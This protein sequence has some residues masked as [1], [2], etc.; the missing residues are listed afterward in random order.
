V[1]QTPQ[2]FRAEFVGFVT[3]KTRMT[4]VEVFKRFPRA[5]TLVDRT[6]G[7]AR[8]RLMRGV[9][10]ALHRVASRS[11]RRR[12]PLARRPLRVVHVSPA[13]F[14]E[15]SVIGGGE[16]YAT[17]L[18]TAMAEVAPTT[19]VTFGPKRRSLG[20]DR[21]MIEI[22][23][24]RTFLSGVQWDPVSWRF[25]VELARA[26]VIHCH[27]YRTFVSAFAI[28]VGAVLRKR[29]FVTDYG[30]VGFHLSD[31]SYLGELVDGFLPI[32]QFSRRTLDLGCPSRVIG[33]GVP[34]ELLAAPQE[35]DR[36]GVLFVGRLLPHKGVDYLIK[37]VDPE[38][39]LVVVGRKF[40]DTYFEKLEVLAAG[41]Q[42]RFVLDATDDVLRDAYRHAIVTVLPSVY[43]D[44][45]GRGYP[46]PELL[47]LTLLESMACGTPVICTNVGGMPEF[48]EDGVT[49]FVVQPND[50]EAL[51]ERIRDL[52]AH[53]SLARLMGTRA[54][55]RAL[56]EHAWPDVVSKCLDAYRV[57]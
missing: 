7:R 9:L 55:E 30:G 22:Y 14:A 5:A 1:A 41:K 38:T 43:T 17:C 25:V 35:A 34:S 10:R 12:Q 18:A 28:A 46:A 33:G 45:E 29:V 4:R 31:N 57:G 47:G 2:R 8:P 6:A 16:R 11:R 13:W 36:E 44:F 42:V 3:V 23:P 37:A 52:C 49:G 32:S 53:P 50:V 27:Q 24:A 56:R 19:L 40:D 21:L 39:P 54:R 26:D 51:R 20:R 48:V 15:E